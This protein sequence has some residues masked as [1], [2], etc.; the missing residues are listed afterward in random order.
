M[1]TAA[2]VDAKIE[3]HMDLC[4]VRYEGISNEMRGVNA[5]LKRIEMIF[6]ASAGAIILMLL[7]LVL[8]N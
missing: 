1:V 3:A 6:V 7:N 4:S 2:E 5:R 8:K